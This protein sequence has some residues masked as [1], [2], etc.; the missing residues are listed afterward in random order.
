MKLNA[1]ILLLFFGVYQDL[2]P[3]EIKVTFP[4]IVLTDIQSTIL[5][6]TENKELASI[7]VLIDIVVYDVPLQAGKG[8]FQCTFDQRKEILVSAGETSFKKEVNPIPLWLSILPPLIAILMALIFRE[9]VSS[10]FLGIFVGSCIIHIYSDGFFYGVF[11]GFKGI[12]DTYI[13][14]SLNDSGHLS[15]IV[16]SMLIGGMVAVISKNGGMQGVVDL[17]SKFAKSARSGQ[18]VTWILGV[19]IFFDDYAN[20]LI[21]GS[22]MRPVTDRFRISREKL[23]Y[24]VDS[25]AAPVAA[26]AFVTTWIGAELGYIGNGIEHIPEI[27]AQEGVY[28]IFLNSLNYSFYPLF[29][30]AFMLILIWKQR[31]FGPMYRAEIRARTTGRLS[32]KIQK[33]EDEIIDEGELDGLK[34]LPGVKARSLNAI[35]P[36]G[37]TIAGT[38]CALVYTGWDQAIWNDESIAWSRKLSQII[39]NSDS[40]IA[41][42]WSS[43]LGLT[44]AVALSI[45]Q[46]IMNISDAIESCILGFKTMLTAVTI[47]VLAWSLALV[48]EHMHT[49]DFLTGVLSGNISSAMIPAITFILAG[50]V[51]FST[52]SSW[53]TMAIL[54][55]LMLPAAWAISQQSGMD[56]DST[57]LIFYNTVSCVLAG[58]VLGDHCSPISDTTILSSLA[59]SCNHIDHVRTQLPYALTVGSIAVLFGTIPA[60]FGIPSWILFPFGLVMLYLVVHFLG[61]PVEDYKAI[62]EGEHTD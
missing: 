14:Q 1:F 25:T 12:I 58:S 32:Q 18:F 52:G 47:L 5:V 9:V 30:L 38:V 21:V 56:Y 27:K 35:I 53:G 16:F 37:L 33:I 40:Y 8:S 34:P 55:P 23:S 36:V 41:L 26:I 59:S 57:M 20:T 11:N 2:L 6:E 29:T 46:R 31:D 61:K 45:G 28:S 51:A 39:G 24:I 44:S 17:L 10:L 19:V 54:Y 48:T 7:G 62:A 60:G 13:I 3:Q 50:L 22:T 43:L 15:V 42:L 49:A 4:E